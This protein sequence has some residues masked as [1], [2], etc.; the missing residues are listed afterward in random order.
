MRGA[1]IDA[2]LAV[3]WVV[4]EEDSD[5]A[6]VILR[7]VETLHA[8]AHWLAEAGTALWAKAAIHRLLSAAEL[9]ERL[10]F[11]ASLPVAAAPLPGLIG[12]A[13]ALALDLHLTV[14]DTLYL[15][16]AERL[17]LPLVTADRKLHERVAS[18]ARLAGLIR[19]IG[20]AGAMLAPAGNRPAARR[21]P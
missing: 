10:A 20:D 16:L 3:K 13:G 17:D 19:W 21:P 6:L 15:A 1:V 18:E 2:S 8:P 5:R 12:A 9:Q 14:Y 7:G 4:A 11:L